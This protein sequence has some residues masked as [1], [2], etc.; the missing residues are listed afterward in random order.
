MKKQA[1]R[2]A[3][4]TI[5]GADTYENLGSKIAQNLR[6]YIYSIKLVNANVGANKFTIADRLAA[7]AE[8]E[9]DIWYLLTA[10]ETIMHPDELKE[11]SAPIYIFEGSSATEDRYIRIKSDIAAVIATI[12]Y[13]DEP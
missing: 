4:V 10:Y 2:T 1:L 11:D 6:R 5:A 13:C 12:E 8:T 9:K 7:A 3:V